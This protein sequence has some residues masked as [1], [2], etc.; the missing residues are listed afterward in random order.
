[1]GFSGLL[2]A[3]SLVPIVFL[4]LSAITLVAK[5]GRDFAGFYSLDKIVDQGGQVSGTL[6]FRLYN[7]SGTD[8]KQAMVTVRESPP[9]SRT[10]ASYS[11]VSG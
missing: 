10:L 5:N 1:M 8:L 7:Y 6:T 9:G 4:G 2:R 11:P 3:K